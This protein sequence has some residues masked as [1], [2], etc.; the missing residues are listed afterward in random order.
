MRS[1]F[2]ERWLDEI[3]PVLPLNDHRPFGP[4]RTASNPQDS[5]QARSVRGFDH[6]TTPPEVRDE[7]VADEFDPIASPLFLPLW[8]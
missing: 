1:L 3:L 8:G 5:A 4:G 2:I 7:P 6:P